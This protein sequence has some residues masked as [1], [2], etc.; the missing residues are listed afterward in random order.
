MTPIFAGTSFFIAL[1]LDRDAYHRNAVDLARSRREHLLTTSA[2]ILEL[3]AYLAKGQRRLAF[4]R[5]TQLIAQSQADVVQVDQTL[6][7]RGLARFENRRDKN[8]SL[9]DCISFVVMEDRG[10][11][12]AATTDE[13]F[14]QA[15]FIALL[16]KPAAEKE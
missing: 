14:E 7:Q 10:I 5:I 3:G 6:M 9:A 12:E 11:T 15:G 1:V 16:R 2:I 4:S 8:W 13:H